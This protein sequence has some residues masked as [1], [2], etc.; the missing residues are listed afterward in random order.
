MTATDKR[1][2]LKSA[3]AEYKRA[4]AACSAARAAAY[5]AS[6]AATRASNMAFE[7]SSAFMAVR[8]K[9]REMVGEEEYEKM[10]GACSQPIYRAVDRAGH[11]GHDH[12]TVQLAVDCALKRGL[13]SRLHQEVE[14][15]F[16][17][18]DDF[19]WQVSDDTWNAG[20]NPDTVHYRV[21]SRCGYRFCYDHHLTLQAA[22]SCGKVGDRVLKFV[23]PTQA[24]VVVDGDKP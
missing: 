14:Q 21:V 13:H 8:E 12:G 4:D 2:E 1:A 11:C 16:P 23:G 19:G 17:P 3:V 5:E 18:Y 10:K 24:A 6:N 15:F 9:I 7:C 22:L 20:V